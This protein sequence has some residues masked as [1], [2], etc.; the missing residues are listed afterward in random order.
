MSSTTPK[1][2][3]E[4]AALPEEQV[5]EAKTATAHQFVTFATGSEVFAVGMD[6]VQEIIRAPEVVRVPLAPATLEGLANLRGK[7][8]PIISLRGLFGF[9][10]QEHDDATRVVVV[11]VGQALGF[12]V[13]RVSSV[14]EVEPEKIEDVGTISSTVDTKLLTGLI[15]DVGGHSMIMILDFA[16]LVERE[17]SDIAAVS[18]SS[19]LSD[20]M[21]GGEEVD[22]RQA[23]DELQLVSFHVN[24][25]E[26]AV[27]IDAVQEIVQVPEKIAHVPHSE[28]HVLGVMT[29]RN[30]L[31]PLVS[32]RRLFGLPERELDEKSRIVVLVFGGSSVGLSVDGVNEVLRVPKTAVDPMPMLLAREEDLTDITEI[33]RL[34]EGKRLVSII[35]VKNLFRNSAVK[36]AL[37]VVVEVE[38]EAGTGDTIQERA[39]DE[40]EQVVVFRLDKEEFGVPITNVEEIVRVPENL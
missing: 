39:M 32:L 26:Y 14:I 6:L 17:F 18:R 29:L 19:G 27:G 34:D 38:K 37:A 9:P 3:V 8:L 22:R 5:L 40:D 10:R 36:A 35:T 16:R 12:V 31:L 33:C 11:D 24:E 1:K 13:D 15:K 23:I 7:V 30:K 21:V 25:Q 4:E 2:R 20:S 28:S